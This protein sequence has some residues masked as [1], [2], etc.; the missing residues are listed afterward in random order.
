MTIK[1][2]QPSPQRL[3]ALYKYAPWPP[4]GRRVVA[5]AAGGNGKFVSGL[6]LVRIR[7]ALAGTSPSRL[8]PPLHP[9]WLLALSRG[10]VTGSLASGPLPLVAPA[11]HRP[12]VL[13]GS[14]AGGQP[15]PVRSRGASYPVS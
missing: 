4:R 1:F 3:P 11:F 7:L 9:G 6:K 8:M 2:A 15:P 12:D 5:V 13:E 14:L 10:T